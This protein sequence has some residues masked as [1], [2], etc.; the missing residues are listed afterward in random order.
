MSRTKIAKNLFLDEYIPESLY[1]KFERKLHILIGLIDVRLVK[2][3]QMLRDHFGPVSINTW[4]HGGERNWSGIRTKDCPVFSD[5]SQ[6]P[7]GRASDKIF[8]DASA[9]EVRN[10]IIINWISLGI[11]CIEANVSWVH[12]DVRWWMSDNLLIVKP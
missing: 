11:S 3:D 4:W 1:K 10:Y 8:K 2:A 12:S 6:H 7:F 9:D 5:T